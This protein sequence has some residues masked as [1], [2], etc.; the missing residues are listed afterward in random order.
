MSVLHNEQE[1]EDAVQDVFLTLWQSLENWDAN[2]RA[3]F[4]TWLYR[5]SFN[6]CIDLKRKRKHTDQSANIDDFALQSKDKSAYDGVL[7]NQLS[8]KLH[9]LL[10]KLPETQRMALLLFYYEELSVDEISVKMQKSEQS[11]RSL[12]KRGRATLKETMQH[13]QAFGTW[14]ISGLSQ[15]LRSQP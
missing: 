11:V 4:S 14:N 15:H 7:E 12:L 13:D 2:G 6:K 1:A 5:V 10:E 9:K 3:K 8:K